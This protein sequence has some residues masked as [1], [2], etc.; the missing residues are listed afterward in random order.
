MARHWT[1]GQKL[2]SGVAAVVGLT[3]LLG[4]MA[5]WN[6]STSRA[7]QRESE[8]SGR[9]MRLAGQLKHANA[10]MFAAEKAMIVAGASDDTARLMALHEEVDVVMAQARKDSAEL[11]SLVT[12]ADRDTLTRLDAG[13][14][15]WETGCASC[16]DDLATM[17]QP[18]TMQRLS[19]KTQALVEANEKLGAELEASQ[20]RTFEAQTIAA[21]RT[22]SRSLWATLAILSLALGVGGLAVQVVRGLT[23]QLREVA[24]G[25]NDG[26]IQLVSAASQVASSSQSLSQSSSEQA[27]SLEETSATVQQ[28][29]TTTR[30]NSMNSTEAARLVQQA[31]GLVGRAEGA[32]SEMVEA[33]RGISDASGKVAKIIKAVDELAF[34][35]NIL[36]LNAAVEAARAGEA[37]LGFAVVADEVRNLALR[38]AQAAR[39]TATLIDES[40]AASATGAGKVDVLGHVIADITAAM[41]EAKQRVDAVSLASVQQATGL[42]QVSRTVTTMEQVTQSTAAVAEENAAASE[43]LNAQAEVARQQVQRLEAMVTRRAAPADAPEL[44]VRAPSRRPAAVEKDFDQDAWPEAS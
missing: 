18:E 27:A 37:G 21:D 20:A 23:R 41:G 15:A 19:A 1:V 11:A 2:Y 12:G 10:T 7:S 16:H 14:D 39:D 25:L 31:D 4:S 13:M 32:L 5:I 36:A 29:S 6:A 38:S 22:A 9:R 43:E 30:E 8:A 34:Q 40:M 17:G 28:L 33:M 35:T 24:G 3:V 26:I 44:V 42:D